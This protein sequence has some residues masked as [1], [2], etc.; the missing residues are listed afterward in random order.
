MNIAITLIDEME[1]RPSPKKTTQFLVQ[2]ATQ[3]PVEEEKPAP[4]SDL[5]EQKMDKDAAVTADLV[6]EKKPVK[7]AV[8]IIDKTHQSHIERK[9]ILENLRKNNSLKVG[10]QREAKEIERVPPVIEHIGL[11]EKTSENEVKVLKIEKQDELFKEKT[12]VVPEK[13]VTFLEPPAIE[14]VVEEEFKEALPIIVPPPPPIAETAPKEPPMKKRPRKLKLV[15][16]PQQLLPVDLET[17]K[18]GD[19]TIKQ[20]TPA[21]KEKIIMKSSSY[22]MNNRKISVQKLN[23]LLHPYTRE[24][25]KDEKVSCDSRSGSEVALLTH[26]KIVRD[27]LNLYTPY[28]GLLLYH[29]LGA[30]KT[31]T[32]IAI[33]EGM[34]SEKQVIVMT[35]ASLQMNFLSE[36]KKCGDDLYK[37]NQY[38]EFISTQGSPEYISILAKS[39]SLPM[40]YIRNNGGAW[41]VNINKEANFAELAPDKQ[42]AIDEQ[43]N[44]MIRAKY[45]NLNYNGLNMKKVRE[46][47]ENQTINPFDHKVV[48]IDEAHNFVSRILNKLGTKRPDVISLILYEYLLSA[49]DCKIVLLSGTPI[50]NYPNEI[51]VLFNILRG[52]INS[53]RIPLG[54][55]PPELKAKGRVNTETILEILDKDN[56][57]THDY[58]ELMN[59]PLEEG[60]SQLIVT[61]N[62]FGFINAKKRGRQPQKAGSRKWRK[63]SSKNHTRRRKESKD[64]DSRFFQPYEEETIEEEAKIR[65]GT[66][67]KDENHL[68]MAGGSSYDGVRLDATG[69]INDADFIA[70]LLRVLKKHGFTID[71]KFIE[72][73]RYKCLPDDRD[74]F[75]KTFIDDDSKEF[76][77]NDLLKRRILGLTSYFRSAQEKLLPSFIKTKEDTTTHVIKCEMSEHQ[78]KYYAEAR[79]KER[80]QEKRKR[81]PQTNNADDLYKQTSS[82][83][84]F[85]RLACNF[86]FPS[87]I[88]RPLPNGVKTDGEQTTE[89]TEDEID[90][91][92][93]QM[94]TQSDDYEEEEGE[95][96]EDAI[97]QSYQKRLEAAVE[98]LASENH[99][100]KEGLDMYSPK[101]RKLLE[102]LDSEDNA[103][104]QLIYTQFRNAEGIAIIKAMLE[105]NG[106]AAFSIKKN[107]TGIWDLVEKDA[108]KGKP[109]FAL[110]T[111]TE[112]TEEKEI[113]RNIFNSSWDFVPSTLAAKL[114]ERHENNFM[115]EIVKIL[116]ITSS[117]AEGINLRNT[118][119]VHIIEPYWHNVRIQQV[120]GRARRICSHQ[121]LPEELRTVKVF[122]YISTLTEKQKTSED[123]IELKTNDISKIDGVTPVTTD[124]NLYEIS[125]MKEKINTQILM[126]IKESAVDCSLYAG[127]NKDEPM[128]CYGFGKVESDHF[129]SY[130]SFEQDRGQKTDLNTRVIEWDADEL[131]IGNVTYAVNKK[132]N[133][134]YDYISYLAAKKNGT[135]PIL[136][137]TLRKKGDGY[138]VDPA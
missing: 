23:Q 111:G 90:A 119:F 117:G 138:V 97:V 41:L 16:E 130:P 28:R 112:T 13:V 75:F 79:M 132:T 84:I 123:N 20:R 73:N 36:M 9:L 38:W 26:Q 17:A 3:Q 47:T 102:N 94:K 129:S 65:T 66:D 71:S 63:K 44:E 99:L 113:I 93:Q 34:K 49:V 64:D 114:K 106:Y 37:K 95:P 81:Q 120:I 55:I 42:K 29:S 122:L 110:Y 91:K 7:R 12:E 31:C 21:P 2:T 76:T 69:N 8:R 24:L 27:Y 82:Y 67:G 101:F 39:L 128:V 60:S 18:I 116:M 14:P 25:E 62:P 131:T 80:I 85:S 103:G 48:I 56:F 70:I 35:P 11:P 52:Y 43:L 53:W 107:T 58:I 92:T 137:G 136:L 134:L 72:L 15:V 109:K 98:K 86:V 59:N 51:A 74:A 108:D 87:G 124:E 125:T 5:S 88:E 61:R 46:F 40:E 10:I 30:G 6:P 89:I 104:L 4:I 121:D 78:F 1:K 135:E 54:K 100:T 96:E 32:S 77:N 115:G 133:E 57:R 105:M 127:K 68:E 22:Y 19:L 126:A 83:R 118:R 33:A 45:K 50:I